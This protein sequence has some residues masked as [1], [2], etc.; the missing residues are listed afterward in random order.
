MLT[1]VEL[2]RYSLHF[3]MEN[4]KQPKFRRLRFFLA[5][6]AGAAG[7]LVF[8]TAGDKQ[9]HKGRSHPLQINKRALHESLTTATTCSIIAGS[10]S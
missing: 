5:Q 3:R 6:E 7:G 4:G 10:G 9:F 8:E 2:E 1:G